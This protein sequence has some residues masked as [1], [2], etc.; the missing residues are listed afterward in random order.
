MSTGS[1]HTISP[2]ARLCAVS[3]PPISSNASSIV[4]AK[5]KTNQRKERKIGI[6]PFL[7][8]SLRFL[9]NSVRRVTILSRASSESFNCR[10]LLNSARRRRHSDSTWGKDGLIKSNRAA[11]SLLAFEP[12]FQT[13]SRGDVE[14][15]TLIHD[16]EDEHRISHLGEVRILIR[17]SVVTRGHVN[18]HRT[19]SGDLDTPEIVRQ[20]RH[21]RAQIPEKRQCGLPCLI[22]LPWRL[23]DQSNYGQ[24]PS[25]DRVGSILPALP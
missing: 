18:H 23:N 7:R 22:A 6:P 19:L 1:Q 20:R 15:H 4:R 25:G 5:A 10:R 9:A 24:N 13:A 3:L 14:A 2:R 12:K 21:W 8:P 16:A 17:I 11:L